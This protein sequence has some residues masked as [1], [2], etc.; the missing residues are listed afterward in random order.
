MLAVQTLPDTWKVLVMAGTNIAGP[1]RIEI[2][3]VGSTFVLVTSLDRHAAPEAIAAFI[4]D[5]RR[6]KA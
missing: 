1:G 2:R 5:A 4:E 3:V 6:A